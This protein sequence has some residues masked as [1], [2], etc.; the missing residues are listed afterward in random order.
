MRP[1][2]FVTV[3]LAL[4][5]LSSP[6]LVACGGG[7]STSPSSSIVRAPASCN[8]VPDFPVVTA[9]LP[10]ASKSYTLAA[11]MPHRQ[12]G[13]EQSVGWGLE[14]QA[15]QMGVGVTVQDAGG[16]QNV[17]RQI[18]QVETAISQKV[19]ALLIYPVS[20][21]AMS[22]V[23]IKAKKAGLVVVAFISPAGS[24]L[25]Q[26][27]ARSSV[28]ALLTADYA[29]QAFDIVDCLAKAVGDKGEFFAVEGG[30]GSSYQNSQDSGVQRA[31][32]AHPG[33][34]SVGIKVLPDFGP[35]EAQAAVEDALLAH[36]GINVIFTGE[37][38][39]AGGAAVA[40][41]QH[42][43]TGKIALGAPDPQGPSDVEG[44]RNG[45]FTTILGERP[46]LMGRGA[47]A[48]AVEI[49]EGKP[50]ANKE[51]IVSQSDLYSDAD[52]FQK[53]LSLELAPPL[54]Q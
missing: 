34:K 49:L 48:L 52:T 31:L 36:P 9:N 32:Q 30:A 1:F 20:P 37:M 53:N 3:G 28:D 5:I 24:Q 33:V 45:T 8:R 14:Q 54:L 22:P 2:R 44:L 18:S 6:V 29:Q 12:D 10:R 43:K 15:L 17:D 19:D 50:L 23:I 39:L 41:K 42:N 27:P 11:I 21:A 13:Y 26:F 51:I 46:V 38:G 16:Y 25:A 35:S 40:I 7:S 47:V 4:A